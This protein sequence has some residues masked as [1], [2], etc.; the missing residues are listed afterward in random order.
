MKKNEIDVVGHRAYELSIFSDKAIEIGDID[1]ARDLMYEAASL[2][3]M[4]SV[5]ASFVGQQDKRSLRV[6]PTV[7]KLLIPHLT[8]LGFLCVPPGSWKQGTILER[9]DGSTT[10]GLIIGVHKFGGVLGVTAGRYSSP[11]DVTY[12]DWRRSSLRSG[13]LAYKTQQEVEAVCIR[14]REVID[15][16]VLLWLKSG[17]YQ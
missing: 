16:Y 17:E 14:W 10:H 12:F 6:A 4:Y 13:C 7:R 3:Q 5:R 8:V 9:I 1:R 15:E 11:D 2:D